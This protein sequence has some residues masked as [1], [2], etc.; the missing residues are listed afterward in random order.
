MC[1]IT[2]LS[3]FDKFSLTNINR[4]AILQLQEHEM[5]RINDKGEII[6]EKNQNIRKI[7]T[8]GKVCRILITITQVFT[9]IGIIVCI[10][11]GIAAIPLS[12]GELTV[13]GKADAQIVVEDGSL[14]D[15]VVEVSETSLDEKIFNTTLKLMIK[16][17]GVIDGNRIYTIDAAIDNLNGGKIKFLFLATLASG[18]LILALVFVVLVFA[19]KLASSLENCNSPFEPAVLDAMKKFGYSL[20]PYAVSKLLMGGISFIGTAVPVVVVL[21]FIWIFRYGAELQQES[22][23]T[24]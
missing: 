23:E 10:I 18:I 15:E 21:M 20:I 17:N 19:K 7:N 2:N 4:C 14:L 1:S 16:D 22:D 9:I 8:L 3:F 12:T 5:F 13:L 11:V 6:M 24:L